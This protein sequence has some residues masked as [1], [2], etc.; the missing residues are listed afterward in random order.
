MGI[1]QVILEFGVVKTN[2]EWHKQIP[3]NYRKYLLLNNV[4]NQLVTIDI[5]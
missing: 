3:L 4:K 1:M 5:T 2:F